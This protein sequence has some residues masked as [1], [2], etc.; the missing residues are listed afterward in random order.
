MTDA[1]ARAHWVPAEEGEAFW[2]LGGLYT[3]RALEAHTGGRYSLCEVHGRAGFSAPLH[4]HEQESE[5]FYVID[6]LVTLVLADDEIQLSPGGFGLAPLGVQHAFRLD[7][8]EARMLLMFTPGAAH[9]AMFAEM[10]EPAKTR[11]IP[12]APEGPPDLERVAA[13]AA[14]HGT[15]LLGPPPG[16]TQ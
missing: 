6:G 15:K 16:A 4:L 14:R 1:E 7:S 2:L 8:P 13:I 9:E 5:G 10:G 12:P 3:W 11:T